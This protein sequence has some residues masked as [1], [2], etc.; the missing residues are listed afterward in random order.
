MMR[1]D[2]SRQIMNLLRGDAII[3]L[4]FLFARVFA[5]TPDGLKKIFNPVGKLTWFH[6]KSF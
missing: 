3:H 5:K 4:W 1:R 2:V 6:N